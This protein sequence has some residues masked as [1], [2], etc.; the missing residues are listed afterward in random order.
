MARPKETRGP[1]VAKTLYLN[2][3]DYAEFEDWLRRTHGGMSVSEYINKHFQNI[4]EEDERKQQQ[5]INEIEP[6]LN[7]SPIRSSTM[8]IQPINDDGFSM[9]SYNETMDKYIQHVAN[10]SDKDEINKIQGK[11][12]VLYDFGKSKY[13]ALYKGRGKL[14]KSSDI[15]KDKRLSPEAAAVLADSAAKTLNDFRSIGDIEDEKV[16]WQHGKDKND[17]TK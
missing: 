4:L 2:P 11:A 16:V 14:R 13:I 10:S 3:D 1:R 17:A 15:P 7:L 9:T 5:R 12:W 6:R 8:T